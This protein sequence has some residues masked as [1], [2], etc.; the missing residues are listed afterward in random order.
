MVLATARQHG[1]TDAEIR[2]VVF[3]I[4]CLRACIAARKPGA[5]LIFFIGRYDVNEPLIE[6]IADVA[7]PTEMIVFHAMMLRPKQVQL[8]GF[9]SYIDP[10][11]LAP[12]RKEWKP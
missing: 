9:E 1:I 4:R 5:R 11:D 3:F 8:L 2:T 7:D 12:Q 10:L 6:A